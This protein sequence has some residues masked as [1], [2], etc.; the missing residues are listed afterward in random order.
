[1][2]AIAGDEPKPSVTGRSFAT[3]AEA[4]AAAHEMERTYRDERNYLV[5]H[6]AGI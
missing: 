5:H 4:S 3:Q 2:E 1:M 6:T